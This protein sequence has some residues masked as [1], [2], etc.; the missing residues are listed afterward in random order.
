[1]RATLYGLPVVNGRKVH[2]GP[3]DPVLSR[4]LFIRG[5][6]VNGEYDSRAPFFVHNQRLLEEIDD[7]AHRARDARMQVDEQ[8]LYAFFDAL[9]PAGIHNGAAF[10]RWRRDIE[11]A[12]PRALFLERDSLVA[13]ESSTRGELSDRT[14]TWAACA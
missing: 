1:M 2:Y 4:E 9:I 13:G 6:L 12:N 11:K 10:E 5:A 7:L 8:A 14:S 3:I